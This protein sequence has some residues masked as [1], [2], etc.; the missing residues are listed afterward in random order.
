MQF[1][2]RV[3]FFFRCSR[4]GDSMPTGPLFFF[5]FFLRRLIF[6]LLSFY[7]SVAFEMIAFDCETEIEKRS[8]YV[9]ARFLPSISVPGCTTFRGKKKKRIQKNHQNKS[10]N[11]SSDLFK[12]FIV[13]E[14]DTDT[15]R[16][17]KLRAFPNR[18]NPKLKCVHEKIA[19]CIEHRGSNCVS[20]V[21]VCAHALS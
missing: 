20:S 17:K 6:H 10:V 2:P 3:S 18:K 7:L 21:I 19:H 15:T 11:N 14:N 5:F 1:F 8:V 4:S 16:E 9:F 12:I 13:M